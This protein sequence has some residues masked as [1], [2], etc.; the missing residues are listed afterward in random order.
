MQYSELSGAYDH[1]AELV[2]E[3]RHGDRIGEAEGAAGLG[4]PFVEA[5]FGDVH[6][7]RH[8][9]RERHGGGSGASRGQG[10]GEIRVSWRWK[11]GPGQGPGG[12]GGARWGR[13]LGKTAR[14]RR[15]VRGTRC[16]A[17]FLFRLGFPVVNT[18]KERARKRK[19]KTYYH[20]P[21]PRSPPCYGTLAFSLDTFTANHGVQT[22][23]VPASN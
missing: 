23:L 19:S 4:L 16:G 6:V 22:L 11:K 17:W 21:T 20:V 13:E 7:V 14:G 10:F 2:E 1:P 5:L 12:G 18:G 8:L 15:G 3:S 9:E